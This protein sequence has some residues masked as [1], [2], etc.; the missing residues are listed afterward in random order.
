MSLRD[1]MNTLLD[2]AKAVPTLKAAVID[3]MAVGH[4]LE[5]DIKA[6][7][8]NLDSHFEKLDRAVARVRKEYKKPE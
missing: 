2:E 7:K 5:D 1:E 3:L 6:G 4:A 8:R